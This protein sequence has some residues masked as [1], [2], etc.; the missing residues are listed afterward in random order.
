MTKL[1]PDKE[2]PI[3]NSPFYKSLLKRSSKLYLT[4]SGNPRKKLNQKDIYQRDILEICLR[5]SSLL[6]TLRLS[7][8]FLGERLEDKIFEN[9]KVK[10]ADYIRYHIETYF[11]RLT[12][13]KDLILKLFN[14]TYNLELKENNGLEK[15]LIKQITNNNYVELDEL[16]KGLNILMTNVEPIRHKIAHGG[17]H[18][19]IH[20]ILIESKESIIKDNYQDLPNSKEYLQNLNSLLKRN[21]IDMYGIELMMATFVLLVYKKL[22]SKRKQIEKNYN[23]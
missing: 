16:L 15:N 9:H 18:E 14:R 2:I 3:D 6:Q 19:D 5:I 7:R 22:Y 20:L 13:Y 1:K 10:N 17:Y 11:L 12:T 21:I 4:T 23:N 8:F